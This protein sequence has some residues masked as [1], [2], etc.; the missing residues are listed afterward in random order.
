MKKLSN[1]PRARFEDP[2]SYFS[3]ARTKLY[4]LWLSAIYPFV[5]IGRNLSIH[6]A[7]KL[8]RCVAPQI[9]LG[10]S[11]IIWE[12]VWLYVVPNPGENVKIT[13]DDN[14]SVGA[15]STIS[16][17]NCIHIEENVIMATSVLIQDHNHAY[18]DISRS[19]RDQGVTVG[20]R[21]RI[22][23]GCWIGQ[24]AA[25]V[26]NEGDVVI[27]RNSVIGANALVTRSCPPYSVIVGNPGRVA[28]RFDATS[29]FWVGGDAGRPVLTELV[30]PQ[31]T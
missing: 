4:T 29:G 9:K 31:I 22:E 28:K 1:K 11:V 12:D 14:C 21:I 30:R 25:I 5:S 19:I 16:A 17:K 20:G 3:R 24:G 13:I 8:S 6:Y 18:E 23:T 7:I 2:L 10:S 27:G 15:R 26:C